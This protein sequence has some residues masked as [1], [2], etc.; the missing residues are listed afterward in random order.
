M[1][2]IFGRI[3]QAPE[4]PFFIRPIARMLMKGVTEGFVDPNIKNH[5]AL[6][7]LELAKSPYFAGQDLTGADIMMSFPL[8]AACSRGNLTPRLM[9]YLTKIHARPGYQAALKTGGP[10]ELLKP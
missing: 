4:I 7:D 2:L 10:Y 5:I 6:W 9:D 3:P 8:E 1:K